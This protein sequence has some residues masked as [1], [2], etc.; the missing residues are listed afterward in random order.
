MNLFIRKYLVYEDELHSSRKCRR[1]LGGGAVMGE[2]IQRDYPLLRTFQTN[3]NTCIPP[4]L[5]SAVQV[6]FTH[7][8]ISIPAAKAIKRT[9]HWSR[10]IDEPLTYRR[11]QT[12]TFWGKKSLHRHNW[13]GWCPPKCLPFELS[14]HLYLSYFV[15]VLTSAVTNL[16]NITSTFHDRQLNSMTFK[17]Y[18]MKFLNFMTFQVFHDL[19]EPWLAV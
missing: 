11:R 19:Y 16:P 3:G 17:A 7:K 4:P 10:A 12:R 2:K 13:Q 5:C 6:L 9:F 18:K 15:L 1:F 8:R 14:Y